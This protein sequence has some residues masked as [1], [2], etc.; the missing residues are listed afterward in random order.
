MVVNHYCAVVI[1]HHYIAAL[2]WYTLLNC[3]GSSP[4]YCYTMVVAC[5]YIA[6]YTVV[7]GSLVPSHCYIYTVVV[8]YHYNARMLWW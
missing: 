3:G 6:S 8:A 7:T 1:T 4:L 2:W 5:P